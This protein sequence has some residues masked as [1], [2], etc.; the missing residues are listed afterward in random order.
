MYLGMCAHVPS[1]S[2]A[3]T[4]TQIQYL[5]IY[6]S[7]RKDKQTVAT[8]KTKQCSLPFTIFTRP[9]PYLFIYGMYISVS[10]VYG[11]LLAKVKL[12]YIMLSN[13]LWEKGRLIM[14]MCY[15]KLQLLREA[16]LVF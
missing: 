8:Y 9:R 5:D 1:C 15:Q 16:A 12:K 6:I 4:L 3:M 11:S 10:I 14:F 7:I 13:F 2:G